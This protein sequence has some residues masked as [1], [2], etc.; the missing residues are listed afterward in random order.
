MGGAAGERVTI[1][2]NEA[3]GLTLPRADIEPDGKPRLEVRVVPDIEVT[4]APPPLRVKRPHFKAGRLTNEG[5][6]TLPVGQD[7]RF[8]ATVRNHTDA[9]RDVAVTVS[10]T[11]ASA[12]LAT[13]TLHL[14]AGRGG[15]VPINVTTEDVGPA[16][17]TVNAVGNA[18]IHFEI[19]GTTLAGVDLTAAKSATLIVD[20]IATGGLSQKI[21]LNGVD[22]GKLVQRIG[23][24]VWDFRARH[25]LSKNALASLAADNIIEIETGDKKFAVAN[26]K[27]EVLL[28]GRRYVVA[29][30]PV[31]QSTP[32]DWLQACGKS[33]APE[34]RMRW[35]LT[36]TKAAAGARK[37]QPHK[38]PVKNAT[39]YDKR[40]VE[41]PGYDKGTGRKFVNDGKRSTRWVGNGLYHGVG[42]EFDDPVTFDTVAVYELE[43]R[44]QHAIVRTGN[45]RTAVTRIAAHDF[46]KGRAPNALTNIPL[47]RT[48]TAKV[49]EIIFLTTSNT[50]VP[51]IYE[52]ELHRNN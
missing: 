3:Q 4:L 44:I 8:V 5:A 50:G 31:P 24:P 40:E 25:E 45:A 36:S 2:I 42:L 23:T 12:T 41:N 33:V 15:S 18:T 13:N 38:V 28:P 37:P 32:A 11:G 43:K 29:A 30:D 20:S 49:I 26:L 14:E 1:T 34:S 35:T 16:A 10:A 48:V 9:T 19:T 22:A 47:G 27:L 46:D 6:V 39:V 7:A 17:L 21:L 52:L 51:S